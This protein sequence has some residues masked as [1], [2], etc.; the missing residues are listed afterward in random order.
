MLVSPSELPPPDKKSLRNFALVLAAMIVLMFGL[1]LPWLWDRPFRTWPWI[2]AAVLTAWGLVAP[3]TLKP[4]HA[5]WMRLA[6]VLGWINTR[7]LL[8]I[9]FYVLLMPLGLA[10]RLFS[11]DAM[12]RKFD[13]AIASYRVTS[14]QPSKDNLKRPF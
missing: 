1:V 3:G 14:K 5:A 6:F 2:V 13:Q 11:R 7:I 12:A 8:G 9:V 4:L 10:F